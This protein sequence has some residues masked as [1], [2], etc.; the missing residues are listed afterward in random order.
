MTYTGV[1]EEGTPPHCRLDRYVAEHLGLLSR[2]QI[3]AR[4]LT[5]TLNGRDVKISRAVKSGDALA[6]HW[7]DPAPDFLIPEDIPL[8]VLYE[9]RRVVVVNKAQGMVVHPGA[10]NRRGTLANALLFRKGGAC[11]AGETLR[12]GIV[13]R[14]DKDTSG[15]IIAA[16]D[17]DALAFLA[18]QFKERTARKTYAAIVRGEPRSGKGVIKTFIMRDPRNRKR[19]TV[20]GERGKIALTRYRTLYSWGTHSL[21][22]LRP[23]TG[24]THQIRVHLSALGHPVTG[25]TIYTTNA[26]DSGL[27]LHAW[28]LGLRLPCAEEEVRVFTAPLPPRFRALMA[29]LG[30][31]RPVS[32]SRF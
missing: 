9:D 19:F 10:G 24:R 25:D 31:R 7:D 23:K 5:A 28:R 4:S 8:D 26:G 27:M 11:G 32:H 22:L 20:S 16:Y 14:L 1:V 6:L 29:S 15:V 2:S 21:M 13:H 3:K 30:Q 18:A 12:A 17:T